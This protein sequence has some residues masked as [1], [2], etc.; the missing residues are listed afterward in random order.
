MAP[1]SKRGRFERCAAMRVRLSHAAPSKRKIGACTKRALAREKKSSHVRR[2][3]SPTYPLY[4]GESGVSGR[5][6]FAGA[7]VPAHALLGSFDVDDDHLVRWDHCLSCARAARPLRADERGALAQIIRK[8][9]GEVQ[10][11]DALVEQFEE[12]ALQTFC[13]VECDKYYADSRVRL[14]IGNSVMIHSSPNHDACTMLV[15]DSFYTESDG[16]FRFGHQAV[17][18]AKSNYMLRLINEA[19]AGQSGNCSLVHKEAVKNHKR[20]TAAVVTTRAIRQGEELIMH[21]YGPNYE[22]RDGEGNV[23]YRNDPTELVYLMIE[24]HVMRVETRQGEE[25]KVVVLGDPTRIDGWEM[26]PETERRAHGKLLEAA[27][28]YV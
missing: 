3:P 8:L 27:K 16:R 9:A 5:G 26:H 21:T 6:A 12:S 18:R 15:L 2:P 10:D 13:C 4:E 28:A 19:P 22:G 24:N 17:T 23:Y 1:K 25:G 11:V 20:V 7:D 14:H